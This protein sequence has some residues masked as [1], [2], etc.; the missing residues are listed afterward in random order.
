VLGLHLGH[1]RAD[2]ARGLVNGIILESRRCLAVLDEAGGFGTAIEVAGGSAADPGFRADLADATG[3]RVAMPRDDD[4]D[5][6]ARGAALIAALAVDGAYP[7]AAF[8]APGPSA[9]PDSA[10]TKL[11]DDLWTSYESARHAITTHDHA[12]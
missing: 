5:Y 6:S 2:L 12:V 11:W 9:E 10:R 3:R 8:P 7:P 1:G 4:T